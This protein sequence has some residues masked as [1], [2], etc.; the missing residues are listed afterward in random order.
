M[1]PGWNNN[2][3]HQWC[4]LNKRAEDN[5][6]CMSLWTSLQQQPPLVDSKRNLCF[7]FFFFS[8]N[9]NT[10]LKR[11][12]EVS[13]FTSCCSIMNPAVR[14]AE[15]QWQDSF[16]RSLIYPACFYFRDALCGA[17]ECYKTEGGQV[18]GMH[19]GNFARSCFSHLWGAF[20][21]PRGMFFTCLYRK[22]RRWDVGELMGVG[23]DGPQKSLSN[24][25]RSIVNSPDSRF[26][27]TGSALRAVKP[28][29]L[30]ESEPADVSI[31]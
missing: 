31:R 17:G 24:H 21:W 30:G 14:A 12:S 1:L 10:H 28:R 6:G 22:R 26:L 7:W 15:N 5:Q 16:L 27:S 4:C 18:P 23:P 11:C 19:P 13:L 9:L 20:H 25:T 29:W 8:M 3:P 2:R